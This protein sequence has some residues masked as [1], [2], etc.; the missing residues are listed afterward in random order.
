VAG[1]TGMALDQGIKRDLSQDD[2]ILSVIISRNK[3]YDTVILGSNI[4]R[5]EFTMTVQTSA[6]AAIF[7]QSSMLNNK[8]IIMIEMEV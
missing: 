7:W 4:I 5:Q 6:S 8:Y 2:I 3:S 1:A